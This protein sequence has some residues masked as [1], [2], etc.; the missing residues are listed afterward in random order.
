VQQ[1]LDQGLKP[2]APDD[3]I[4]S[5]LGAIR[6]IYDDPQRGNGSWDLAAAYSN[7]GSTP[8]HAYGAAAITKIRTWEMRFAISERHVGVK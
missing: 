1:A 6:G 5:S 3:N 7:G 4:G 2:W 8:D